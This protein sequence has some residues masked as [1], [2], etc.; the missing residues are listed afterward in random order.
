MKGNAE[1]NPIQLREW[2]KELLQEPLAKEGAFATQSLGAIESLLHA[3]PDSPSRSR[4][5]EIFSQILFTMEGR[6][7]LN[8][9]LQSLAEQ[10]PGL[11][12][13]EP[14]DLQ[15]FFENLPITHPEAQELWQIGEFF[16]HLGGQWRWPQEIRY[17]LS[18]RLYCTSLE[19]EWLKKLEPFIKESFP[20][21]KL[22]AELE[23]ILPEGKLPV[24]SLQRSLR[25]LEQ[26]ENVERFK[27]Q[28]LD[29]A[30]LS[31]FS[32]GLFKVQPTSLS[33]MLVHASRL[34]KTSESHWMEMKNVDLKKLEEIKKDVEWLLQWLQT[35]PLQEG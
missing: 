23:S 30:C 27:P 4:C 31:F 2:V 29:L 18:Q 6:S 16:Q 34:H 3:A 19:L 20:K 9:P 15:F 22:E 11:F 17:F 7:S 24:K 14:L 1:H 8:I 21:I 32:V 25:Y 35:S 13:Q 33:E 12:V 26:I 10:V 28:I 5:I